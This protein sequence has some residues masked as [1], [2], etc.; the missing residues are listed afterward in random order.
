VSGQSIIIR[1]LV[2]GFSRPKEYLA[3]HVKDLRASPMQMSARGW[4]M[5]AN[6]W[7]LSGG[8]LAFDYGARAFYCASGADEAE[9]RQ[10][11]AVIK[12]RFPALARVAGE[13]IHSA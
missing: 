11:V 4:P 13:D 8:T 10:I 7:G 5:G 3:E 9:A 1:R 2:L 6:F 12:G